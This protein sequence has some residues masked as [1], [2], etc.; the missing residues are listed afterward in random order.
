MDVK[1]FYTLLSYGMESPLVLFA[2]LFNGV[3][4]FLFHIS[5]M[6]V[7]PCVNAERLNNHYGLNQHLIYKGIYRIREE[8]VGNNFQV[9]G[10]LFVQQKDVPQTA[11][12]QDRLPLS[13]TDC[14]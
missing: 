2:L 5:K 12:R 3:L 14:L 11:F 6:F 1:V 9:C 10:D 13:K 7:R 8:F 4:I